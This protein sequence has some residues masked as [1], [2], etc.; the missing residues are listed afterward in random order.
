MESRGTKGLIE[1]VVATPIKGRWEGSSFIDPESS[2]N[3]VGATVGAA[4]GS[5]AAT[6]EG[7][8]ILQGTVNQ[9][10]AFG[11]ALAGQGSVLD[12]LRVHSSADF[13]PAVARAKRR[14][15][16]YAWIDVKANS[17]RRMR[18]MLPTSDERRK[19][20]RVLLS[21]FREVRQ[22][23]QLRK[24]QFA[25]QSGD[26]R[27]QVKEKMEIVTAVREA[28]AERK[29][30]LSS[31]FV[32]A[33]Q[34]KSVLERQHAELQTRKNQIKSLQVQAKQLRVADRQAMEADVKTT[35]R[36]GRM[37]QTRRM[38]RRTMREDAGR[39]MKGKSQADSVLAEKK[40]NKPSEAVLQ[41][42]AIEPPPDIVAPLQSVAVTA[43]PSSAKLAQEGGL[44]SLFAQE[45][46]EM[47]VSDAEQEK[48]SLRR[49]RKE[50]V[51]EVE[52]ERYVHE[53]TEEREPPIRKVVEFKAPE[54][55]PVRTQD[56]INVPS[57]EYRPEK[58]QDTYNAEVDTS[59]A[60]D[61]RA[62]RD[63]PV[64]LSAQEL[65]RE[66]GPDSPLEEE[67]MARTEGFSVVL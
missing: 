31:E 23:A 5:S 46:S 25:P 15:D 32:A 39:R 48:A 30:V 59:T 19:A 24:A 40:L 14:L 17:I 1:S 37:L 38:E 58:A 57:P 36:E 47:Q 35:Q 67:E 26:R 66:V 29:A 65:K 7:T 55:P 6:K 45:G 63:D 62:L 52:A 28:A 53:D 9:G 60:I 56:I 64:R 18:E 41:E 22:L 33:Q 12:S 3:Q 11:S 43:T 54:L 21:G 42:S 13:D 49:A 44:K 27:E 20:F 16:W 8:G 51:E 34:D 50:V 4:L 2:G 10:I 61:Q